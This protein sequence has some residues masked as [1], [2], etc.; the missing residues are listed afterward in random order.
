MPALPPRRSAATAMNACPIRSAD[1]DIGPWSTAAARRHD[2]G[3]DDSTIVEQLRAL[4]DPVRL[5]IV[6]QL[7]GG[8]RCACDLAE[9]ADV[10]PPL[11]SHHL[12]VLR[13][14]G[15][16]GGTKRGRWTDY[17]LNAGALTE[18][19]ADFEPESGSR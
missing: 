5:T 19:L 13:Q 14:A 10:S 15:L 17:T 16:I 7:R 18:L 2:A 3:V 6:R 4:G 1:R 8:P 11:L 9:I 12:K